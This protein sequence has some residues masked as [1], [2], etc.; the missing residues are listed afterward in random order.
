MAKRLTHEEFVNR[1]NKLYDSKYTV[2]ETYVNNTTKLNVMCPEHGIWKCSPIHFLKGHKCPKCAGV[3]QYTTEEFIEKCKLIHG[4]K[5]DFSLVEYNTSHTKVKVICPI[6]GIFESKPNSLLNGCG[7]GKC[8]GKNKTTEDIIKEFVEIHGD[9][10]DYSKVVYKNTKTKVIVICKEHGEFQ[11]N[12][13]DH[14]GGSNCPKCYT[15]K[16]RTTEDVIKEFVAVHGDSFDYSLVEYKNSKQSVKIKCNTCDRIYLQT[17][18]KHL[19]LPVG[20]C[21]NCKKRQNTPNKLKIL[22]KIHN[23]KYEYPN[24][25]YVK[26]VDKINVICPIHGKFMIEYNSHRSGAGCQKCAGTYS[27]TTEEFI[28]KAAPIHDFKYDYSQFI[29]TNNKTKSTIICPKHGPWQQTASDHLNGYG[30]PICRSSKGELAIRKFLNEHSIKFEPQY[31]I[32]ECRNIYPLPFDF[33]ILKDDGTLDFLIEFQGEQHF[34]PVKYAKMTEEQ[35]INKFNGTVF[36]DKIK[37]EFCEN[38]SINILY[39]TYKE[40]DKI[41]KILEQQFKI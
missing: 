30:C 13:G 4:D 28:E 1:I 9:R 40:L 31:R 5:Y 26:N 36:R 41:E 12:I 14:L 25:K 7:C 3:H 20:Y 39:I 34:R 18:F 33:G 10:Y 6:H 2:L 19:S 35:K 23:N 27:Y 16:K 21:S 37:K 22:Q 38:N 8:N 17:P 11:C 29:Y 32:N 15:K 24:F